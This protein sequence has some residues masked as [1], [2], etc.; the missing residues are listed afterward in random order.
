MMSRRQFREV[1]D[2]IRDARLMVAAKYWITVGDGAWRTLPVDGLPR[3][4]SRGPGHR[5]LRPLGSPWR[6][7]VGSP[8]SHSR[9]RGSTE[10]RRRVG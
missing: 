9:A 6:P 4:L 3:P 5:E 1:A 8:G 10:R 7:C 2:V